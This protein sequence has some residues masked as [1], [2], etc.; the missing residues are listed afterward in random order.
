MAKPAAATEDSA[1]D[2]SGEPLERR[3]TEYAKIGLPAGTVV[4]ALLAGLTLGPPSAVLILAGGALVGVIAMF[5]ASVRTLL[6]E[7]PLAGADAYALG[8][9]RAEE[10]QKRAV[11]RALKDLEFERSVGKISDEDYQALVTKYR[12]EAKRL[13]KIL[14]TAAQPR[15]EQVEALVAKRLKRERIAAGEGV[16]E[17]RDRKEAGAQEEAEKG[18][19]TGAGATASPQNRDRKGAGATATPEAAG[20]S[21]QNRDRNEAGATATP[22]GAGP[23]T[24]DASGDHDRD[25]DNDRDNDSDSDGDSDGDAERDSGRDEMRAAPLVSGRPAP[26]RARKGAAKEGGELVCSGCGAVNDGD[27]VFCKKCGKRCRDEGTPKAV[28]AV[29]AIAGSPDDDAGDDKDAGED[30]DES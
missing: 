4:L 26:L 28:G 14:D 2:S 10:E 18:E 9:P 20:A 29:G 1:P 12:T 8:A 21:P 30:E 7:T 24:A 15:R 16:V 23:G 11:L 17:N 27:A 25:R 19:R 5:W 13:L 3:L 22:Q 6:G